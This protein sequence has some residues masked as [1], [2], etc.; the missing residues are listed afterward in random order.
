MKYLFTT[1]LLCS[2]VLVHAQ[3]KAAFLANTKQTFNAAGSFI[4][5]IG[6][7]GATY[8]GQENMGNILYGFE[9]HSMPILFT[10]KGLIYLQRKVESISH[11]EKEKL[12]KQGLTEEEIEHKKVVTDRAIT[13]EWVGANSNVEIVQEDKTYDYHTYGLLT[14]KA[15]G[16]KKITYKNLYNGIDLVYN[17]TNN[18]KIGFE[19]SLHVAAGADISQIKMRYG[20]DVKKIKKNKQ[21]N[22]II[23]SDIDGVE[24]TMPVSYYTNNV[25]DKVKT[26]CSITENEVSFLFREGYNKTENI[27]IDPFVSSTSNLDGLY[28]GKAKD[29]DF[30]YA[31]NVYVSGGGEVGWS[32]SI[33]AQRLAK[34]DANGTLLWTFNGHLTTPIW[35][36]GYYCGGW[37][38]EKLTGKIYIGPGSEILAG[39]RLI[40]LNTNGIYDNYISIANTDLNEN[41]KMFWDCNNGNSQLLIAG[42]SFNSGTNFGKLSLPATTINTFST[43]GNT[44]IAQDIV[45]AVFDP[46]TKEM[47]SIYASYSAT[48][49]AN[50]IFK[51]AA[52]YDNNSI[53]WN[54]PSGYF[55]LVEGQNRPYFPTVFTDP[56][57]NSANIFALNATYLF[58]WDGMNLKAFNKSTGAVAG[59]LT[60]N[61]NTAKMSGGIL[62]DPLNNI[63]VGDVNGTI[64]SY[65]F[66]GSIFIPNGINGNP[67]D[68]EDII[69]NDFPTKS[70]YDLAYNESDNKIYACGDGFVA[71]YNTG[72]FIGTTAYILNITANCTTNSATATLTP[73]P[74]VGSIVTYTL[75]NGATQI[76][77]NTTGIF[78]G[79]MPLTTYTIVATLNAACSGSQVTKNFSIN[80]P[81]IATTPTN[82]ICG[83]ALGQIVAL[84]SGTV[85]PYTYSINGTNFFTTTTF[86]GLGAGTYTITVKDGNGCINTKQVVIGNDS[87]TPT[88]LTTYSGTTCGNSTGAIDAT[89]NGGAGPYQY[90]INNGVSY[91]PSNIFAGLAAGQ[92]QLKVKDVNGCLSTMVLVDI[93]PSFGVGITALPTNST[94]G[95]A[96]GKITATPVGGASPYQ[97]SINGGT[98]YQLSNIFT[99]L[100]AGPY[101][102]KIKDANSCTNTTAI[103]TVAN[104]EGATVTA[105]SQNST[106]GN[107]NGIITATRTGGTA[108]F[109]Y[110]NDNGLTYQPSNTFNNLAASATPYK[111]KVR[112]GN[113]CVS[114]AF[115]VI[116]LNTAGATVTATSQNSTCGNANGIITATRTGGTT[117][118]EYSNDNGLTYQPSNTFNNLAASATPYKI[119]VRDGNSCISPAFDVIVLN[120][121]GAT[122]TATSQNSTCGNANGII[123]AIRTAGTANFEYSNDNGLTYQPSSTFNNLAANA[124]AYKIKV[125]DGNNC[126]S[127]AF[128]V[129][130]SNTAGATVTATSQNS[131]CGSANGIITA[132]RTDGT[133]N[134]EYSNDNGLTYQPSNTFNNLAA[135]AT[136]YKI[137]VRDGNNCV[138]PAFDVIVLNTAGATVTAVSDSSTCGNA[139]GIITATR[140]GGTANFEY[141]NNNGLTYQPSNTFNNLTASATPYKIK[142][143]DGNNC[144]SPAFDIVVG[145][146]PSATVTATSANATCGYQN[147]KI[148]ALPNGQYPPFVYSIDGGASYQNSPSFTNLAPIPYSIFI[149]DNNNCT[150][151]FLIIVAATPIPVLNVFAGK[152]TSVVINQPLQLNAIDVNNIGFVSYAW[153]P[154]FGLNRYDVK[155][156]IALLNKDFSYEVMAT[157]ADGC[158]ATDSIKINITYLSDIFVPTAFTPN[159]DGKN[160]V[161]RPKLIGVKELKYFTI[162]NRYGQIIYTTNTENEGWNGAIIGKQQ[163]NGTYIWIAEAIDYKGQ[164]VFRK[165]ATTLIR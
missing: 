90:S 50:K 19:Y 83:N 76:S 22:L 9:G 112:D 137:K 70:V 116:V 161:L 42:G 30:D 108:N 14:D 13:M 74:A 27:I 33:G 60:I 65:T 82:E 92:Y 138:S 77:S 143:R 21:G 31:G 66:N 18:N 114:P 159:G 36:F 141:S 47:Y 5:N 151:S 32:G 139:N 79:I 8:K 104:T 37:V 59:S 4:E 94:C 130:V 45:D 52:P 63:Y 164:I 117:N 85:A 61:I 29:I 7:Y 55:S 81:T 69:I 41:W 34:Y 131:T 103:I 148:M 40:R 86:T 20:G 102:I 136:P 11:Q 89:P 48:S 105:T 157:T 110:S 98:T 67:A 134:F 106:C 122:V 140:T 38:V 124:T 87:F 62:A 152:D 111:I 6:Q 78:T 80:A 133:A 10:K 129:L 91:Q 145:N 12:E 120:T 99:G 115:D 35:N 155:N 68:P 128:D 53:L 58:Y 118:F 44:S 123:T 46:V 51:H 149:K 125:R 142:V 23:Q 15:Y 57:D 2:S 162:Y 25:T 126:V 147:G 156:P 153:S 146:K 16:Y 71:S 121:A 39:I 72:V 1:I 54:V 84:G 158:I 160:D 165:G 49:I 17:F 28:A 150:T 97:Y 107:A 3:N 64:A 127:P 135:S 163:N 56:N 73:T 43:I 24:E 119:K 96:N 26:E 100:L 132:T 95:L 154:S 88:F 101:A 113:N 75:Y 109:E 93:T 144:V